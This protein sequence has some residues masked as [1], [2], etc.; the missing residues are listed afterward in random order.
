MTINID[1]GHN[2]GNRLHAAQIN[3]E[4]QAGPIRKA[5][6]TTGAATDAGWPEARFT[7]ELAGRVAR[8]LRAQG[9]VIT[10]THTATRPVWGPCITQ[11][12][13][14]GNR[15]NVA[16]SLHADG[17][18]GARARGFHIIRPSLIA[19]YTDDI[20]PRSNALSLQLRSQLDLVRAMP[21]SNYIGRQGI[22]TRG[23][24]GGL[25]LSNVPKVFLEA[26]NMRNAT[27]ARLLRS[28]AHQDRVA[29]AITIALVRWHRAELAA[30]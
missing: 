2:L 23:D 13:A 17:N 10:Y 6:D 30:G 3:R 7:M 24:L 21:R 4:V 18:L 9:A 29:A 25:V 8:R 11:R 14:I 22:D 26:G 20:V 16:I 27:D 15:A 1:P 12:A 5:C 19:G 28:P